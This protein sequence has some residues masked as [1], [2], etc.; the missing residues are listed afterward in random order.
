MNNPAQTISFHK[1]TKEMVIIIQFSGSQIQ[2]SNDRI[3]QKRTPNLKLKKKEN[4]LKR[5]IPDSKT[6]SIN[7]TLDERSFIN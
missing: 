5:S 3:R 1:S 2:I 4:L 6:S 7:A